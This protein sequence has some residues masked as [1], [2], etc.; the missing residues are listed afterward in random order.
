[1]TTL[2]MKEKRMLNN[3]LD[4]PLFE[5]LLKEEDI[6]AIDSLRMKLNRKKIHPKVVVPSFNLTGTAGEVLSFIPAPDKNS[7]LLIAERDTFREK[8]RGY[9]LQW[10]T[11]G[12]VELTNY[13]LKI[14]R[15]HGE[16]LAF[17]Y[18]RGYSEEFNVYEQE[19]ER[20]ISISS[21]GLRFTCY[22]DRPEEDHWTR[23][24]PSRL[25]ETLKLLM[26]YLFLR[27][28]LHDHFSNL[29]EEAQ[30]FYPEWVERLKNGELELG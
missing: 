24:R 1:M 20:S 18:H 29:A 16:T 22:T 13:L 14:A 27:D 5:T 10:D 15:L 9:A 17:P 23:L 3:L 28:D 8:R 2:N 6:P 4:H 7:L 11:A 26:A 21:T 19:E 25:R 12:L 30:A